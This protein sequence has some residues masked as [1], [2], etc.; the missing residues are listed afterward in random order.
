MQLIYISV[1]LRARLNFSSAIALAKL[2]IKIYGTHN[3]LLK[4]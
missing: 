4:L 3:L 2:V 1:A